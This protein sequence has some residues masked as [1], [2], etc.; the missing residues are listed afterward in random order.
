MAITVEINGT[1]RTSQVLLEGLSV[2]WKLAARSTCDFTVKS[3]T[4][5]PTIGHKVR[6]LDGST[7][8]YVG[9]I[10]EFAQYDAGDGATVFY[11]CLCVS[12]EQRLDKVIFDSVY[13]YG[14]IFFTL[15]SISDVL[16]MG[17][18]TTEFN[19]FSN[20]AAVQM[21]V[22][23]GGSL[24]G[25]A[26]E[27]TTY[28]VINRTDD[29]CQLSATSGGSA[30]N[31]SS[32]GS[33]D[34]Y[35]VWMAGT[36]IN[37]L[38]A[39][40]VEGVSTGTIRNGAAV[41]S[42][43]ADFTSYSSVLNYLAE[44]SGYI[45]F[46]DPD[47]EELQFVSRTEYTAPFS[48]GNSS[49]DVLATNGRRDLR[50]R[51]TREEYANT[52]Y[53]KMSEEYNA[54]FIEGKTA[55]GSKK[56]FRL[57]FPIRSIVSIDGFSGDDIGIYGVDTGKE[58]YYT[59]GDYWI[60]R[61][62]SGAAPAAGT[63][64]VNYTRFGFNQP[65]D[66]GTF[67]VLYAEDATEVSARASAE[68][69]TTGRYVKVLSDPSITDQ[70]QAMAA[71]NAALARYK[72]IAIEMTYSTRTSGVLPGQL[73]T[74]NLTLYGISGTFLID[75]VSAELDGDANLRYKVR[76]LSTTRLGDYVSVFETF[77][78]GTAASGGVGGGGGGGAITAGGDYYAVTLTA[79][80]TISRTVGAAGTTLFLKIIQDGTG[81]WAATPS[82]DFEDTESPLDIRKEA[83][84]TTGFLFI[85]NG[86]KW[87]PFGGAQTKA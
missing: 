44:L 13:T 45:W 68:S 22:G 20:G 75:T 23:V 5:A 76:A 65:Y 42:L 81:G 56:K 29:T 66:S 87:E 7:A 49:T 48:V 25:G 2:G 82:S 70:D 43:M 64:F 21:R 34:L 58:W 57:F 61:S 11:D 54:T 67:A 19:P 60:V 8:I 59:P 36:I 31:F 9:S 72:T 26:S 37:T 86:T 38:M 69:G 3:G 53:Q 83:G 24:P 17:N 71:A 74:V 51:H 50:F 30:V 63:I 4:Y 41:E 39:S 52:I 1:D 46:I 85:S 35:L 79:D 77:V 18:G 73:Q 62:S 78:G 80:A 15:N 10:D 40:A 28:Y 32:A 33:G 84:A 6:V 55:D 27:S 14:K 47:T 16:T 12:L